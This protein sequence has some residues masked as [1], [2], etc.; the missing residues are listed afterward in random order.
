MNEHLRPLNRM[1]T[2]AAEGV[3]R[4]R[5]TTA[6]LLRIAEL[7][8]FND[9]DRIELIGGEIVPM[10]PKVVRDE[11]DQFWRPRVTADFWITPET[12]AVG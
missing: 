3:P 12:R 4:W 8:A 10:S 5:W 2:Q 9:N 1:P 11:L 7:G 6:E